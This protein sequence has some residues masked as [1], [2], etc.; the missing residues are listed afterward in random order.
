MADPTTPIPADRREVLGLL[1]VLASLGQLLGSV[2]TARALARQDVATF[3]PSAGVDTGIDLDEF[4]RGLAFYSSGYQVILL[5]GGLLLASVQPWEHTGEPGR[6]ACRLLV[7][8][9]LVI[10]ALA[11]YA[12]YLALFDEGDTAFSPY[13]TGGSIFDRIGTAAVPMASV[14]VAGYVAWLA[15]GRLPISTEPS[16]DEAWA[17][18]AVSDAEEA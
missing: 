1:L 10:A 9:G 15:F 2:V 12:T 18:D 3:S 6:W 13:G 11:G 5:V 17:S 7:P 16:P 8:L 14:A 4:L